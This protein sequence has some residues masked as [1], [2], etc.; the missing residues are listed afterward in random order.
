MRLLRFILLILVSISCSKNRNQINLPQSDY[1][2]YS[3]KENLSDYLIYVDQVTES[4][5]RIIDDDTLTT[6][7]DSTLHSRIDSLRFKR[8]ALPG[9]Q[10]I[11]EASILNERKGIWKFK[12]K[13]TVQKD[14]V[15]EATILC[16]DR[17]K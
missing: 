4:E 11:L 7:L 1:T 5:F 3:I 15:A 6:E 2:N 13:A 9:D 12:C 14:L 8:P 17:P 10:I 16:A